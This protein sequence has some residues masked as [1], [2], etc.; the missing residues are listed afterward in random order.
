M[1]DFRLVMSYQILSNL[2]QSRIRFLKACCLPKV[3]PRPSL[4]K[5]VCNFVSQDLQSC[6]RFC[7]AIA[8]SWM[9]PKVVCDCVSQDLQSHMR[10]CK[11]GLTSWILPRL[12]QNLTSVKHQPTHP[13][14]LLC[15]NHMNA[16][17]K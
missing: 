13:S 10:F 17:C 8:C 5:V 2:A 11:P 12:V 15:H 1:R 7:K 9:L 6:I 16:P 14:Y 4:P 3:G